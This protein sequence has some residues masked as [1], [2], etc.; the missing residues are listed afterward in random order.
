MIGLLLPATR[1]KEYH[2]SWDDFF[3]YLGAY[4]HSTK[5]NIVIKHTTSVSTRNREILESGHMGYLVP[6]SFKTFAHRFGCGVQEQSS[7]G[8]ECPFQFTAHVIKLDDVWRIHVP[9]SLQFCT[10]DHTGSSTALVQRQ[11]PLVATNANLLDIRSIPRDHPLY[12]AICDL[13]NKQQQARAMNPIGGSSG[14]PIAPLGSVE[15]SDV[16][17]EATHLSVDYCVHLLRIL[18][19]GLDDVIIFCAQG[20]FARYLYTCADH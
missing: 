6:E 14:I 16:R 17:Y 9:I 4:T 19:T 18:T 13:A 11:E 12:E 2:E 3:A 15:A 8:T 7:P 5:S 1:L 20:A 10:H